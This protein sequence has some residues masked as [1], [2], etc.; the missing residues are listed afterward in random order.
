MKKIYFSL[1][2]LLT[3][4]VSVTTLFIACNNKEEGDVTLNQGNSVLKLTNNQ[5]ERL[6]ENLK[7]GVPDSYLKEAENTNNII[8]CTLWKRNK[9]GL[10]CRFGICEW[11]PR[12]YFNIT[13]LPNRT[14]PCII[15][16]QSDGK[17]RPL[18][19][20]LKE[21]ISAYPEEVYKFEIGEDI[22]IE[23]NEIISMGFKRLILKA[24]V[25]AYDSKI[26]QFGGYVIPLLYEE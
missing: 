17:L 26:G 22:E 13:N 19:V 10:C 12:Q 20:E 1:A 25:Y 15:E 14:I 21:D 8:I 23:G 24:G 9:R 18:I 3:A 6:S 11:F 2:V 4:M 5:I 16:K 7:A